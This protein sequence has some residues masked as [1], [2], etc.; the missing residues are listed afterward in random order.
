MGA[1][2]GVAAY[3]FLSFLGIPGA[4]VWGTFTFLSE[5]VP[6]LGPYLMSIPPILVALA[7]EPILALWVLLFYMALNEL[8][9]D[10]LAPYVRSQQMVIH[11][12]F[13]FFMIF[14]LAY[15]F[16]LPGAL[17]ATPISGFFKAF[18]DE[19]YL[20]QREHKGTDSRIEQMLGKRSA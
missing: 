7:I 1:V 4:L 3:A 10:F 5:F 18:Y 11:P 19:F 2:E 8:T 13:L 15:A 16:G 17:I 6:R 20:S 9:G 12:V 14:A